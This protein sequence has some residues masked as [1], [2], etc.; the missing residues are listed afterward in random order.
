VDSGA[1]YDIRDQGDRTRG[2]NV[3][4]VA[5]SAAAV[6][7]WLGSGADNGGVREAG[8]TR[9]FSCQVFWTKNRGLINV[10]EGYII[11]TFISPRYSA[12]SERKSR[13][14]SAPI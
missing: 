14:C 4:I 7:G 6:S 1:F 5:D 2:R 10:I 8:D 9:Y 3:D 11:T 13:G 12:H